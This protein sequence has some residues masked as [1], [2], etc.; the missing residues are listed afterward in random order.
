[1]CRNLSIIFII[2]NIIKNFF[3]AFSSWSVNSLNTESKPYFSVH[4]VQE[5][6]VIKTELGRKGRRER[7][8]QCG[9]QQWNFQCEGTREEGRDLPQTVASV[10]CLELELQQF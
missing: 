5:R 6:D 2:I 4:D 3:F 7:G 9:D 10:Q 1:V 8:R